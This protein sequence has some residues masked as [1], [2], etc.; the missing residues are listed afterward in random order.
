VLP[1]FQIQLEVQAGHFQ[2]TDILIT[3]LKNFHHARS[4]VFFVL[5][6]DVHSYCI[7]KLDQTG[8]CT[9]AGVELIFVELVFIQ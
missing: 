1:H 7:S 3:R 6:V 9:L 4:I 8:A 2:L 5:I